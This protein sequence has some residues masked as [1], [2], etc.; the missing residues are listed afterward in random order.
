MEFYILGGS[1]NLV[2][3]NGLGGFAVG[4]A[5]TVGDVSAAIGAMDTSQRNLISGNLL[6]GVYLKGE[7]NRI[8]GNMI[9]MDASGSLAL[10]NSWGIILDDAQNNFIGSNGDGIGDAVEGNLISG[11]YNG[12]ILIK[13]SVSNTFGNKVYGNRIGVSLAGPGSLPNNGPGVLIQNVGN[14]T[15]GGSA[16]Y[17]G[18]LIMNHPG[19]G[20]TFTSIGEV[21]GNSFRGNSIYANLLGIDLNLDGVTLE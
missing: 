1:Q 20:I 19:R 21:I 12:G 16:P 2:G 9:G 3:A 4:D 7:Q 14:N 6:S 10:P 8:A 5:Y 13:K 17:L 15:I 18:N 11:N